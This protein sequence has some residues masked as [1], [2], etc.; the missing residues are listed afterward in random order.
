MNFEQF[1]RTGELSDITVI[2]DKT[3]FK[4]HTFPLFTKSRYFKNA[5]A[6]SAATTVPYVV[7][8]DNNF[9]GGAQVFD[10]LADYFYSLPSRRRT[11][12]V[13]TGEWSNL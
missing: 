4:L 12:L 13:K 2:V 3:E 9:P 8:L 5:V 6:S 1:R 7:R 11:E 10:Q